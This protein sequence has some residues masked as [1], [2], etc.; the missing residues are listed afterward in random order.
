MTGEVL[1]GTDFRKAARLWDEPVPLPSGL[2]PVQ[3]LEPVLV[4]ESLRGWASDIAE[5]MRVPLDFAVIPA[6][7]GLGSLIG[8]RAVIQPKRLDA[9][10]QVVPNLWG[11]VIA[12]PSEMKT[13]A[14]GESMKP[15][16]RLAVR[17]QEMHDLNLERFAGQTVVSEARRKDLKDKIAKAVRSGNDSEA[18][19]LGDSLLE[20]SE[21]PVM[22]RYQTSDATVEKLG[23]LLQQNPTGLLVQRDELTGWLRSLDKQ[24]REGDRSFF[25]EAWNGNGHFTVD[26]IARGSL[27]VP[28]LCL[29]VFGGV[30]PGPISQYVHSATQGG[31]GD[32]G[33]LQRFQLLVWPDALPGYEHVDRQANGAA[34]DRVFAL[35]EE[36]DRLE[37]VENEL[38]EPTRFSPAGQDI[39]DD[40]RIDLELAIRSDDISPTLEAH[41]G[42][43]RSLMP[44]LALIFH[45][46]DVADGLGQ[47][48]Q[49][50][51]AHA[52]MAA[53]W[54]DYLETHARRVYSAAE[55]PGMASARVLLKRIRSGSIS[56]G[57]TLRDIYIRGWSRLTN[58]AEVRA[59]LEVLADY[60]FSRVTTIETLGRPS[61]VVHFHP[62]VLPA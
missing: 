22:R 53:A 11:G 59:A 52:V 32:D 24:G 25:L 5:R 17:A 20:E 36:I 13:P 3:T 48:G 43:Y 58:H 33:L 51:E 18:E 61:E 49:V 26:R 38:P 29:S 8:R 7:I 4:P 27:F 55:S 50:S 46:V 60:G 10:W 28:A 19:R 12:R 56:S 62:S 30:Q 57:C 41:L 9:E 39:F 35:V 54:C 40:W 47:Q 1:E 15:F 42:K 37:F 14:F 16:N 44:T 45:L 34:R 23:V 6:T 2:P 21:P 31:A